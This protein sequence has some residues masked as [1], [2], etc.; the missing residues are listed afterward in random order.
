VTDRASANKA[1]VTVIRSGVKVPCDLCGEPIERPGSARVDFD[2][3]GRAVFRHKS[4][5]TKKDV[6][7][8]CTMPPMDADESGEGQR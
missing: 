4:W 2:G 6:L 5:T 8:D 1:L 7:R 3:D